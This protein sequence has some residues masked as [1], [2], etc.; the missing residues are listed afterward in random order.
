M[1]TFEV[2]VLPGAEAEMEAAFRWL[3]ERSPQH[4]PNWYNGII[5]AILSLEE[6][7]GRCA[8][9]PESADSPFEIRQLLY[10]KRPHLYRILFAIRPGQV[11]VLH[12]RHAARH[13]AEGPPRKRRR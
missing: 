9:A 10:G 6:L 12:V 4:A 13:H 1:S 7:P 8:L 2:I 5:D 11:I 3:T